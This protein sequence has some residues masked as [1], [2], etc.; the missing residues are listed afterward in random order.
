MKEVQ[1]SRTTVFDEMAFRPTANNY[2][3]T[4]RIMVVQ[5]VVRRLILPQP[6]TEGDPGI[7]ANTVICA[8]EYPQRLLLN[9]DTG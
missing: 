2:Q 5:S 6:L 1:N 3:T 7:S 8:K 4:R 9:K